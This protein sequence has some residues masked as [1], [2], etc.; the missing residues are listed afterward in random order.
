MLI[1]GGSVGDWREKAAYAQDKADNDFAAI[2]DIRC[3][4]IDD[5]PTA[6]AFMAALAGD[7]KC[8]EFLYHATV[9]LFRCER[10]TRDQ[11]FKVIDELEKRLGLEGHYRIA[12]E[13]IKKD[14]QHYH[15]YWLRLP[16]GNSGPAVNMGND[17]SVH[18]S[19]TVHFEK[20]FGLK[21]APRKEKN[22]PSHKRQEINERNAK[23]RID[24]DAVSK[25]VTRIYHGSKTSKEFVQSLS[26]AGYTLTC[27]KQNKLVLV[28]QKGGYHGL[29]RRIDGVKICDMRQK[30]PELETMTLPSLS[31]VLKTRRPPSRQSFRRVAQSFSRKLPRSTSSRTSKRQG[32]NPYLV[33][34][35][36]RSLA[37]IMAEASARQRSEQQK[38]SYP[39]PMMK[40]RR[41]KKED[42]NKLAKAGTTKAEI[43][44]AELLAWALENHRIDILRDFGI[45]ILPENPTLQELVQHGSIPPN[46]LEP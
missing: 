26:K 8:K 31:S 20:E 40:K 27:G 43:E 41:R 29:M 38:K 32:H 42:E 35:C 21:P 14:R 2:R 16:P 36:M 5:V 34:P 4:G 3:E 1:F 46:A 23:T 22:K 13:H 25:V 18:R 12:F 11:W 28:D 15:I 19:T 33:T 7:T 39:P 44:N 37:S 10:L 24:P 6:M 17:Y 30:F 45:I 9:N